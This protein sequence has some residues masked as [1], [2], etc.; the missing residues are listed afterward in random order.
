MIDKLNTIYADD[1]EIYSICKE[2]HHM[3]LLLDYSSLRLY[4]HQWKTLFQ[5]KLNSL[6]AIGR[7]I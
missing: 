7:V 6:K 4:E 5:S 1:L 2:K 3:E